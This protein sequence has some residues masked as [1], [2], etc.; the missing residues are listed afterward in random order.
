MGA[1][2][3]FVACGKVSE[4]L[5][6]VFIIGMWES[7]QGYR[8]EFVAL[9]EDVK[10]LLKE[11]KVFNVADY[12]QEKTIDQALFRK[13]L[14]QAVP[15]LEIHWE[16][17]DRNMVC[18]TALYDLCKKELQTLLEEATRYVCMEWLGQRI[19]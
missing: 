15:A 14:G 1:C 4:P 7:D 10:R 8:K 3:N 18:T 11:G 5:W 6:W 2:G 17:Q 12:C 9:K 19:C 16:G 13:I